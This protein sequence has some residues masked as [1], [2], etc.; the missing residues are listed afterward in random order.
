MPCCLS[1]SSLR[2]EPEL[3]RQNLCDSGIPFSPRLPCGGIKKTKLEKNP[4]VVPSGIRQPM[5]FIHTWKESTL[6]RAIAYCSKNP[7][8]Q[9]FYFNNVAVQVPG[10]RVTAEHQPLHIP[11]KV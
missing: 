5:E 3:Q 11:A 10:G 6:K 7:V 4:S 1:C 9:S 2:R 8:D